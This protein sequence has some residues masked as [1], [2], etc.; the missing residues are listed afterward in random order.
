MLTADS[1][2]TV[3]LLDLDGTTVGNGQLNL[4]L[5]ET[6]K[7]LKAQ[8]EERDGTFELKVLTSRGKE[9]VMFAMNSKVQDFASQ[10]TKDND[11]QIINEMHKGLLWTR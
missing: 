8:I 2:K 6:L 7:A 4:A 10:R 3:V 1:K 11:I 5:I 9:S